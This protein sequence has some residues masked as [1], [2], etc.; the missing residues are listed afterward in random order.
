M[1][2]TTSGIFLKQIKYSDTSAVFRIYTELFGLQSYMVKGFHGKKSRLKPALF[3]PLSLLELVVS[4]RDKGSLESIRE[5]RPARI[6]RS[7][8]SDM[9][10]NA[11]ILFLNEL[12]YKSLQEEE[13]NPTLFRFI[14]NSLEWLDD[15]PDMP[16]MFHLKFCIELSKHLGFYPEGSLSASKTAFDLAGGTFCPDP[17]MFATEFITGKT[18]LLFMDLLNI[19]RNSLKELKVPAEIRREL[20]EKILLYYEFHIP[21]AKDFKSHKVLHEVLK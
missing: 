17:G 6:F 9:S 2:H 7:L 12:L 1:Y 4:H 3:Q 18:S 11:V 21:S 19:E 8:T 20:L 15:Q 16:P 5:A 14:F 10:K 13:S